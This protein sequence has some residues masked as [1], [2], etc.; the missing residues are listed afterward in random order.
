M[1]MRRL[2]IINVN[3]QRRDTE[4]MKSLVSTAEQNSACHRVIN[5]FGL[6]L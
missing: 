1:A 5:D 3:S 4:V 6:D 2:A